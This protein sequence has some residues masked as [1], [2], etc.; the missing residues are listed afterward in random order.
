MAAYLIFIREK[1][2]DEAEYALYTQQAPEAM[3][4]HTITPHVIY[5]PCQTL[6]GAEAQG[7]VVLEFA[8]AEEAKA[9]YHSPAYQKAC[10]HRH[11][12]SDYRVLLTEGMETN[13]PLAP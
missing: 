1:M 4:G 11:L 8:C 6:E 13:R 9:F 12:G 7:V 3:Q 5:G 10:K 2:R